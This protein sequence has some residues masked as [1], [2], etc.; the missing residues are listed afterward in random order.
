MTSIAEVITHTGAVPSGTQTVPLKAV[1]A[2]TSHIIQYPLPGLNI[3]TQEICGPYSCSDNGVTFECIQDIML[4]YDVSFM[5]R[6]M[7]CESG[8][9]DMPYISCTCTQDN[10]ICNKNGLINGPG[11]TSSSVSGYVHDTTVAGRKTSTPTATNSANS[12][13]STTTPTT[14]ANPNTATQSSGSMSSIHLS[15]GTSWA[16]RYGFLFLAAASL[17]L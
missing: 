6:K 17:Q 12:A 15:R 9:N 14:P 7:K 8:D 13:T 16:I 3:C 10:R 11:D 1:A 4:G 2:T 5:G